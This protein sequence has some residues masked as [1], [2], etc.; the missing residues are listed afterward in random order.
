MQ[1]QNMFS[2][3]LSFNIFVEF[4]FFHAVL[5][6]S[7]SGTRNNIVER[8]M[9]TDR[10]AQLNATWLNKSTVINSAAPFSTC[11]ASA[12]QKHDNFAIMNKLADKK[13]GEQNEKQEHCITTRIHGN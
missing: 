6:S 10:T 8:K 2:F 12:V 11:S 3:W 1:W 5:Q 9:F 4:F 13:V 7:A